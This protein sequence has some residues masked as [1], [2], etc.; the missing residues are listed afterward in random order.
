MSTYETT[1]ETEE[2]EVEIEVDF[3]FQP[4]EKMTHDYPGC[5]ASVEINSV[6][7][8]DG[9]EIELSEEAEELMEEQIMYWIDNYD[10]ERWDY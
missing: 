5:D 9:K 8:V 1:I 7:T 4:A 3:D 6:Q 2:A 10:D